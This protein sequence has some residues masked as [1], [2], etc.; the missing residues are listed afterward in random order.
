MPRLEG[1]PCGCL[2]EHVGSPMRHMVVRLLPECSD[3]SVHVPVQHYM[4]YC[5]CRRRVRTFWSMY[6][7]LLLR[8]L[9]NRPPCYTVKAHLKNIVCYMKAEGR[10]RP[11]M[12]PSENPS[13]VHPVKSEMMVKEEHFSSMSQSVKSGTHALANV[14]SCKCTSSCRSQWIRCWS[15]SLRFLT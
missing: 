15:K 5:G 6:L 3:F 11:S 2:V 12:S 14:G 9:S 1:S 10:G 13:P 8:L 4:L 7:L